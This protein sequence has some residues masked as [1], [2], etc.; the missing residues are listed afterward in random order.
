M[1]T[2]Y[3]FL[4]C[5]V[6]QV[7]DGEL[8]YISHGEGLHLQGDF[9]I[10]GLFPLHYTNRPST[11]LPALGACKEGRHNKHGFH[12]MQAMRF[13]VE[14][15]NNKSGALHSLLPGVTLG[16]Q[17]Y[18]I[19]SAPA[20]VLATLDLLEQQYHG[21]AASWM[22]TRNTET[23]A[24]IGPDSSSKSFTPAA[25]LGAYL[26]PQISYEASNKKLSNKILYPSFFRTI[27]S[28]KN[29]VEAM[30]QLLVH[31]N[32]TWIALLGSDNDYGLGGMQSLSQLAPQHNI[33][34]A[35]QGVIPSYSGETVKIMRN[36]VE[37]ILRAKVNT[38]VVFSSKSK[39]SGFFP[40]V[41]ERNVTGKVWI[42][43]E[44]WSVAT[45]I[46]GIAGIHTIGTVLGV[47]IQNADISGFQEFERK[48]V[49]A[50]LHRGD[51]QTGSGG[52]VCL[53][54]TDVYS[55]AGNNFTLEKYDITSS[56]NVYKAV[57]AVAHTLHQALHC[58]SGRCLV[59]KVQPWQL[60]PLLRD[61]R[62]CLK[63][64]CVYFD[65]NGDPPTG[66]DIVTWIWRGTEWSLRVVGSFSPDPL[67]L[68]LDEGAI[69]WDS[70]G[71]SRLVPLSICSPSC[72]KGHRKLLKG[73]HTCCFDCQA[74]PAATFL[75][76]SEPTQCQP[77]PLEQW[78]P[79]ASELCHNRT[80]LLLAWDAPLSM[81]LLFF[82]ACCLLLTSVSAAVL[83]LHLHTPVAKSAGGRTCLLMLAALM[84]ASLS[85]LCH[86]GHPSNAACMLKQPLFMFSF[87]VFL[88]CVT[89]RSLQVVCIFKL[90]SKLPPAYDKWAKKQGPEWTIFIISA[91]ILFISVT[92]VA[93]EPPEPSRDVDFYPDSIVLECSSTLSYGSGLELAYVSLLSVVCFFFN[94]MGKDL[95]A[96]YNEAKCITFSLTV[97]IISWISFFTIYLI[98]RSPFSMAAHV[99]AILFSVT[100]F[101]GGYFLPKI[102][103]ILL[104]PQMN[105]TAHFQNCI[106]MYTMSKQ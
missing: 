54:S 10:A 57:Y 50:S 70:M 21:S 74:C 4:C 13:A 44:D 41:V 75:N 100:A 32:W 102:Y 95:P 59:R 53:Q 22:T 104:R 39:L 36:M 98:S 2:P 78:A 24:V 43:T 61:V 52:H 8:D 84:A 73:Q 85:T 51:S 89:V 20:S 68:T 58:D 31:F 101:L 55:L 30:I 86:F 105:T 3:L 72:T 81:A 99:F 80:V 48:V 14:E 77:C 25:L 90:A 87:T 9:S 37:G 62:F 26:I 28:D 56:F 67:H 65:E 94:Y 91:I 97:Y 66:Y 63:N 60:L 49:E 38:I 15:V 93:M 18:D 83:L 5:L 27:P 46:S 76:K 42:G 23:V 1:T 17:M 33:C 35:F 103:I 40:F 47:S 71:T 19:C 7:A 11:G 96:N 12:M 29:Q 79:P 6:L 45:L 92:H 34:V 106:Q 16:Y 69:E 82:L 64:T 88:A